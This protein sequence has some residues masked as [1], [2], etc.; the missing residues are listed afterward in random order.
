M[1]A[2]AQQDVCE[3]CHRV[4]GSL[5]TPCLFN[6]QVVCFDCDALLRRQQHG[7]SDHVGAVPEISPEGMLLA[8]R[9]LAQPS[10]P[11]PPPKDYAKS[12]HSLLVWIFVVIPL[13]VLIIWFLVTTTQQRIQQQAQQ[14]AQQQIGGQ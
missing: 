2:K 4:I 5:E 8:A 10:P 9:L 12:I 7:K 1:E 11:A 13:I 3:N 6:G 14:Q